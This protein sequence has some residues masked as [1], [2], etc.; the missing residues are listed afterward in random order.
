MGQVRAGL[1]LGCTGTPRPQPEKF[2][3]ATRWCSPRPML[4]GGRGLIWS[5]G[6]PVLCPPLVCRPNAARSPLNSRHLDAIWHLEGHR[7]GLGAA[8]CDVNHPVVEVRIA[9]DVTE[10]RLVS[11]PVIADQHG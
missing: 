6:P 3:L 9:S 1:D 2:S 10:R 4:S 8:L 5:W 7:T 11:L